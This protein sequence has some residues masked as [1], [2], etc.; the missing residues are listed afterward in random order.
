MWW[1]APIT[2]TFLPGLGSAGAHEA[3]L[4]PA[5]A[6][7]LRRK[8]YLPR[9]EDTAFP[10]AWDEVAPYRLAVEVVER[11]EGTFFQTP[12]QTSRVT[13]YL[14]L[15]EGPKLVWEARPYGKT[16]LPPPDM[17]A[18][19]LSRLTMAKARDPEVERRLYQDARSLFLESL[20]N[21]LRTLPPIKP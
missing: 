8:G 14:A 21:A 7:L 10:D 20:G 3:K 9:P 12:L 15:T 19:E 16:R 2:G 13:G 5:L 17:G 6:D 4:L 11:V 1:S 18:F